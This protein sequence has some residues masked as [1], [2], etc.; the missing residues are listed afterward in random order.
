MNPSGSASMYRHK[1]PSA[2][3]RGTPAI[4]ASDSAFIV[5]G[6]LVLWAYGVYRIG[7][8]WRGIPDYSYGWFVPLLSACLFWERWKT[9]PAPETISAAT[10]TAILF[11]G[12]GFALFPSSLGLEVNP[13]WRTAAWVLGGSIVGISFCVLHLLGGR[14]WVHHFAFPVLFFLVAV[15]W[16][17]RF[18]LPLIDTLSRLNA[19]LSTW[20][21]NLLGTPAIRQGVLIETAN[22]FVNIDD[23]C[24]GIRSMQATLMLALFLGELFRYSPGRRILYVLVGQ[25]LAFGGNIARTTYLVRISDLHGNDAVN[26]RHDAAGWAILGAT[27]AGLLLLSR[28]LHPKRSR[29]APETSSAAGFDASP[30]LAAGRRDF[31]EG[32]LS[33]Q[34]LPGILGPLSSQRKIKLNS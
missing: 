4:A 29:A 34:P 27:L 25:A 32:I 20:T 31:R 13:G 26:S 7:I 6:L 11:A 21:A 14:S 33:T 30:E 3:S 9:R 19:I 28:I 23:A 24:S 10:G 1:A 12:F 5:A 16:H 8:L 2:D 22:G 17:S 15:P 18:E